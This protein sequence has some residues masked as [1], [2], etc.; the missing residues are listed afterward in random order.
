MKKN[1]YVFKPS[2]CWRYCGGGLCIVAS[3]FEECRNLFKDG[4]LHLNEEDAES[5]ESNYDN[6]TLVEE[7]PTYD[8]EESRIV[9]EDHN[10]G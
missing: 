9:L 7:I 1:L 8:N 3:S 4:L 5:A 6:W 2:L 10:W